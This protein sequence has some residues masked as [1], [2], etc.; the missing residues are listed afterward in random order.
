MSKEETITVKYTK[1]YE[2]TE[3]DGI[4]IL[5]PVYGHTRYHTSGVK[6]YHSVLMTLCGISGVARDLME[7]LTAKMDN[8]NKVY[9]T[10]ANRSEFIRF[11]G[12]IQKPPTD[13]TVNNAF[14]TLKE[15]GL[16]VPMGRGCYMVNPKYF[17]NAA[18]EESRPRLIRMVLEFRNGVDTTIKID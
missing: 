17:I 13:S 18:N 1:G 3:S 2:K 8:D 11:L 14:L 12:K 4:P 7:W 15:A 9:N 6:R 5:M 10:K 16:L